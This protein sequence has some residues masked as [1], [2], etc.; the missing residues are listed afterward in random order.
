MIDDNG[1]SGT[2]VFGGAGEAVTI[3]AYA[4]DSPIN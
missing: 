2:L 4:K 1:R 3:P